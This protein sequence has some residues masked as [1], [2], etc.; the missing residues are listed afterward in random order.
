MTTDNDLLARAL[1]RFRERQVVETAPQLGIGELKPSPNQISWGIAPFDKCSGLAK[2]ACNILQ[3]T[4]HHAGGIALLHFLAQG[5]ACG[6]R[7]AIVTFDH[8][9]VFLTN[10]N[11]YGFQLDKYL[12]S[13]QL[14]CLYFKQEIAHSLS[15]S[16]DYSDVLAELARLTDGPVDRLALSRADVF[17]NG[18]TAYLARESAQKLASATKQLSTTVLGYYVETSDDYGSNINCGCRA[19]LPSY[20]SLL[21]SDDYEIYTLSWTNCPFSKPKLNLT[22]K[23][24][25]GYGFSAHD[26]Y[27]HVKRA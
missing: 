1:W 26:E 6:Q 9:D 3:T 4:S 23:L 27:R 10:A 11:E 15:F 12:E 5:L 22:L 20:L 13:E 2:G 17:I 19:F 21:A 7:V 14:Q 18:Q 16:V 8:V 25:K 24:N